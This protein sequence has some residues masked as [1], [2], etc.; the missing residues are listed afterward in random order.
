MNTLEIKELPFSSKAQI[1]W[2][3]FWRGIAITIGSALVGGLLG[4]IAGFVLA[5]IGAPR[6]SVTVVGGGLGVIAG[7]FSIYVYVRWLLSTRLGSF[8]L[9]LI[10][11]QEKT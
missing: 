5:L 11:A 8:R 10:H 2:G 4:G 6:V 9:V 1:C 7:A 3:V